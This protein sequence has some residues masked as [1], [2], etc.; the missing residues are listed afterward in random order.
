MAELWGFVPSSGS[1]LHV[2]VKLKLGT[3]F[4]SVREIIPRYCKQL[5]DQIILL[6]CLRS[7]K[8]DKYV[9]IL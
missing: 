9:G 1:G 6:Q 2:M 8:K 5:K 7:S 4:G 3:S